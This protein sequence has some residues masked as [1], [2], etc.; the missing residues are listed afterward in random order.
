MLCVLGQVFFFINYRI[1]CVTNDHGYVP[2]AMVSLFLLVEQP[3]PTMLEHTSSFPVFSW[4]RVAQ[5]FV[6]ILLILSFFIFWFNVYYC[7]CLAMALC[8]FLRFT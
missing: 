5:S 4:V 8:N 3:L 2:V 1:L 7:L 6:F